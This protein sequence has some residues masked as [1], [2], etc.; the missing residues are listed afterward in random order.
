MSIKDK[1]IYVYLQKSDQLQLI[2]YTDSDFAGCID[3]RKST[4]GYV[5]LMAGG[6]VSW[7]SVKQTLVASSTMEAEFVT[8]YEASNQ[9]I[10]L[11]NFVS[12]LQLVDLIEMPLQLYCDNR[13]A[14]LYYKNDKSSARSRHI[15]I[16]FLV[17]KDRVRNNIVSV[18]SISTSLNIA[19]P[20]TEGLSPKVF[21]E[22]VAH[23]GMTSP[24]DIL[25]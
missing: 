6:A 20:F 13:V 11:W 22:H 15:D 17:I 1:G 3:S 8:C 23:I 18:D 12:G 7:K 5:F 2:G 25:V 21:L 19:D 4:S 14:E 9:A 24:N 16:K 10:W